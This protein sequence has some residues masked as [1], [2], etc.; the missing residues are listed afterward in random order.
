MKD[1][2]PSTEEMLSDLSKVEGLQ[3]FFDI[4]AMCMSVQ[5]NLLTEGE[6]WVVEAATTRYTITEAG[7]AALAAKK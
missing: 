1:Q 6:R 7:R 5:P 4:I 2:L 3:S